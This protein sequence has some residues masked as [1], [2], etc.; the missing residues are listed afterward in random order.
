MENKEEKKEYCVSITEEDVRK[1]F[2]KHKTYLDI[3]LDD[4]LKIYKDAFKL[5]IERVNGVTVGE[6]MPKKF[7]SVSED[8]DINSAIDLLAENGVTCAPV[9]NDDNIVTGF[10]SD[11]DILTSAGAV[12]KHIFRDVIRHLI[13][14]PTPHLHGTIDA[15]KIKD[16]MTS[17]AIVV[18]FDNSIKKAAEIFNEKRIK[19][20][21][22][23][24]KDGKL[25]G[26]ISTTDIIK[27]IGK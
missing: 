15:K 4:F 25:E 11:S 1:A 23:I 24:N 17:P 12:K 9:V 8:S 18:S 20:M 26:V 13:G 16:I 5:A 2:E 21:P 10:I 14:E 7:I 27:Y 22:V 3:S 19:R 6:I